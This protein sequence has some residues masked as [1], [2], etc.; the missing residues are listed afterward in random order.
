MPVAF[1]LQHKLNEPGE[2]EGF[3]K[4]FRGIVLYV[5]AASA[6]FN[7]FRFPVRAG[8]MKGELRCKPFISFNEG[9]ERSYACFQC[10]VKIP[11]TEILTV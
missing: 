6:D 11:L 10:R 9:L 2:L 3:I 7:E 5:P 4:T 1:D 8:R